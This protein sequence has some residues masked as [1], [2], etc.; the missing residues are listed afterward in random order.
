MATARVVRWLSGGVVGAVPNILLDG[1]TLFLKAPKNSVRSGTNSH[2]PVPISSGN[3]D[4]VHVGERHFKILLEK[5]CSAASAG[6]GHGDS[7]QQPTIYMVPQELKINSYNPV[8]EYEPVAVCI[9]RTYSKID[10]LTTGSQYR[11]S[12]QQ[13]DRYKWCCV[14]QL[15]RR[16]SR[17]L[18]PAKTLVLLHGCFTSMKQLLPKIRGSYSQG[19]L[20]ADGAQSDDEVAEMMLLDGCFILHRLLKYARR[21]EME[22]AGGVGDQIVDDDDDWTQVYGRCFV[23]QLVTRDLLLLENQ[24]P[25][26]VIQELFQQLRNEGKSE[27]LLVTGSLRLFRSLRPPMLHQSPIA[28]RRRAPPAAS[29]LPLRDPVPQRAGG[30]GVQFRKRENA[31][32]FLDVSFAQGV[33]EIPQLELND[34]SESLFRNLIAFEQTYP[35]TPCDVSTYAVFMDCLI[36]SAEDMRILDLHGVLVSHLS[37]SSRRVAWNF[38]SDIVGKVHWSVDDNYLVGLMNEVNRYRERRRHKWRAALDRNYFSNPW[39]TMSVLAALLLL[40]MAVL[41]TF[42]AVYAYF[43]PP[44]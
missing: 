1:D 34:S 29:L 10:T 5:L 18:E 19:T 37:S 14:Q 15:I 13:L 23:W 24:I 3:D 38:F 33:L 32:S 43:K 6:A 40:S 41:Q 17:L 28:R 16:H 35:D 39:V 44:K 22:E 20:R 25:F 27:N 26:F 12:L 42:F 11:E 2:S 4:D 31:T 36:T 7:T 30:G 8:G 21:A 9:G